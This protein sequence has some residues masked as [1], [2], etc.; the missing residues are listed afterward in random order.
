MN[1]EINVLT[2]DLKKMGTEAPNLSPY[3]EI[4]ES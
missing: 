4:M 2:E 3:N 1:T